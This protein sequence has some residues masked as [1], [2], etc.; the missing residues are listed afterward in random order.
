M[1]RREEIELPREF[2]ETREAKSSSGALEHFGWLREL[3]HSF[4]P[5]HC[6]L[7]IHHLTEWLQRTDNFFLRVA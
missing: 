2:G 7:S 4:S 6:S 5:S 1:Q 3:A